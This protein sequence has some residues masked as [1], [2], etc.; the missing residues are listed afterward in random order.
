MK[1]YHTL[2]DRFVHSRLGGW[3]LRYVFNPI[4]KRLIRWTNGR[5]N[6][7]LGTDFQDRVVLL[8]CT[9]ARSGKARDV[10]VRGRGEIACVAHEAEGEERERAW[11][12]ANAQYSGYT[13]YQGRTERQIPVMIL[14]PTPA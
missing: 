3:M 10:T 2:I 4:D 11:A 5:L 1:A 13:D 6:S 7:G 9:G 12:A 8:R 14:T